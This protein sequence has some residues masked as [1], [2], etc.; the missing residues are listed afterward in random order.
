MADVQFVQQRHVYCA[1]NQMG[2]RNNF[3]VPIHSIQP[4]VPSPVNLIETAAEEIRSVLDVIVFVFLL[5]IVFVFLLVFVRRRERRAIEQWIAKEIG[6]P[7]CFWEVSTLNLQCQPLLDHILPQ[8]NII[9]AISEGDIWRNL[10][11]PAGYS[12]S[13]VFQNCEQWTITL[14][15]HQ[16][17]EL[18][19]CGRWADTTTGTRDETSRYLWQDTSRTRDETAR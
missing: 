11:L 9:Q 15:S 5:V 17:F 7:C 13:R 8:F 3:Y 4:G 19:D 18:R 10:G 16:D 14:Y 12:N 6:R 1:R 2:S